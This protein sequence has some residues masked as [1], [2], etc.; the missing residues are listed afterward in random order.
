MTIASTDSKLTDWIS[1]HQRPAVVPFDERTI[2]D[3]F[4]SGKKGVVLFNGDS[5][6]ELLSAFTEAA[7]A[8]DGESLVFT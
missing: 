2:G 3:I 7:K 5:N 8:Y 1:K 6:E 4:G